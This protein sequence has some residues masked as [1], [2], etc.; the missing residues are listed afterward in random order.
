[1]KKLCVMKAVCLENYRV[2]LEFS[3]GVV[4]EIDLE[5]YL[6][7]PVFEPMRNDAAFFRRMRVDGEA[8]TIVWENGADMDPYVLH[9]DAV[10][11]WMEKDAAKA[12]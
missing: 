3:D 6:R 7:G 9:G 12:A 2:R 11:A 8:G 10:P 1:M 4:R 5:P